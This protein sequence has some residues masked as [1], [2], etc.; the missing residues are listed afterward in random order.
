LE[1]QR[2]QGDESGSRAGII[3]L[4][5]IVFGIASILLVSMM[6]YYRR[7]YFREKEPEV[8]TVIFHAD[9]NDEGTEFNNPLYSRQSI[10]VDPERGELTAEEEALENKKIRGRTHAD[11]AQSK[12]A[13]FGLCKSVAFS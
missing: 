11:R 6:L 10:M 2:Q 8:P 12:G 1:F 7:K 5:L 9:G 4:S 3:V 13:L